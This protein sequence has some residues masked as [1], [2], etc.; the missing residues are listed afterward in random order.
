MLIGITAQIQALE[1]LGVTPDSIYTDHGLTGSNRARPG[2]D[3]VIGGNCIKVP[4]R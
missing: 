3:Q 1:R 2:L 4:N